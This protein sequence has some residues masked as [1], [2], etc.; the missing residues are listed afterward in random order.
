M[1]LSDNWSVLN[2]INPYWAGKFLASHGLIGFIV[3]GAV[4]MTV[5][6]AEALYADMGHFG[7]SPIQTAWYAVVFPCLALNYLGQGAFALHN[8]ELANAAGKPLEDLNWF[9]LMCPEVLRPALVILATMATVIASQAVITGAYS[10]TQQA[11]QL[12]MLPRMQILRTSE[13]QAGQI[14]L[15]GVN[16]LLL[17]GVL[18]LIVLFQTSANLAHA[19][20]IAV[21]G[22]MLVTTGL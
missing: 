1:H 11:I 22:T 7:R 19:Y 16:R 17:V 21:T 10:L 3:L 8:L 5:T 18:A 9:F 14:Y 2:A 4:L 15:P 13:T 12:G 20:G 6:G